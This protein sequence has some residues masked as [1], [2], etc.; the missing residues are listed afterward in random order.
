LITSKVWF[1]Q[2]EK[3][4]IALESEAS[5]IGSKLRPRSPQR[6]GKSGKP[7]ALSPKLVHE[8]TSDR[9]AAALLR[10]IVEDGGEVIDSGVQKNK[11]TH[12]VE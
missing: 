6:S 11:L 3:D 2:A 4:E 10:K 5:K 1:G 9:A 7:G 12:L 8:A